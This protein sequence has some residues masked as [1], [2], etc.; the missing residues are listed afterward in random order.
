M[1]PLLPPLFTLCSPSGRRAALSILIFHRVLPAPDPLFPDEADQHRFDE[2]LSWLKSW[3]NILPLDEAVER[4]RTASLPSRAACIT[5]DDGY[6]DNRTH[7]LPLLQRHGMT[8][9][10]FVATGYLDG[11]RMWNDTVIEAVRRTGHAEIDLS[12]RGLGVV[13]T[14]SSEEKRTALHHLIPKLKYLAP[15]AREDAARFVADRCAAALPDNLMLTTGQL[16]DLHAAGMQIGAHTVTHPILARCDLSTA[17]REIA[18]SKNDLE[19]RI[20]QRVALFAYPNGRADADYT[21]QHVE[22]VA[23]LGFR[24]ALTTNTGAAR[25]GDDAFQLPRF[26]PWDRQRWRFGARLVRNLAQRTRALRPAG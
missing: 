12:T 22:L 26:T 15:E 17:R 11:G 13:R 5:F 2:I 23:G 20:G 24:A 3:F 16:Q 4:L 19:A 1:L 7:A 18:D 14:G 25:H 8:A 6:A 21:R 10:F 9:T